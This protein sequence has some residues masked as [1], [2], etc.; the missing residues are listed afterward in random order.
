M[1]GKP[2]CRGPGGRSSAL[3]KTRKLARN[4]H[5]N[6]KKERVVKNKKR[7][8]WRGLSFIVDIQLISTLLLLILRC[9]ESVISI[10]SLDFF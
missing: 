4:C 2:S 8:R 9:N 10:D 6:S 3:Y 7:V 1:V 5:N